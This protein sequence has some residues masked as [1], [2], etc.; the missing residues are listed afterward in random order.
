MSKSTPNGIE[1]LRRTDGDDEPKPSLPLTSTRISTKAHAETAI[2]PPRRTPP[3]PV[4]RS[5]SLDPNEEQKKPT[6][7]PST[8][9]RKRTKRNPVIIVDS[10][11]KGGPADAGYL[12][13]APS[14]P[15]TQKRIITGPKK[16]DRLVRVVRGQRM[17]EGHRLRTVGGLQYNPQFRCFKLEE[18]ATLAHE[19][20][21]NPQGPRPGKSYCYEDVLKLAYRKHAALK[22]VPGACAPRGNKNEAAV[23]EKG[24]TLYEANLKKLEANYRDKHDGN[25]RP[26]PA[27]RPPRSVSYVDHAI[28]HSYGS[29]SWHAQHGFNWPPLYDSDV[30]D[31]V[32]D[33]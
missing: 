9:P 30:D 12:P 22:G 28:D 11:A 13:S 25:E 15:R 1:R 8:P 5:S 18:L 16:A 4:K 7:T 2:L 31:S 26:G 6:I 29:A 32:A 21:V 33:E 27:K 23:L 3:I 20:F 19:E 10:D 24:K 17:E 14:F